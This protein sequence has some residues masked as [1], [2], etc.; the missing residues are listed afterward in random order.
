MKKKKRPTKNLLR[1]VGISN[2]SWVPRQYRLQVTRIGDRPCFLCLFSSISNQLHIPDSVS[3]SSGMSPR[4]P[5]LLLC[6]DPISGSRPFTGLGMYSLAFQTSRTCGCWCHS[7]ALPRMIL[8]FR[9]LIMPQ[10]VCTWVSRGWI[11][12]PV[13]QNAMVHQTLQRQR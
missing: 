5:V 4:N 3:P 7:A 2:I 10:L 11:D 13:R 9:A 12:R 8:F 1:H 6:R